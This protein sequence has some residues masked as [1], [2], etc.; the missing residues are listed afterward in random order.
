MTGR[1]KAWASGAGLL[2]VAGCKFLTK[3][4]TKFNMKPSQLVLIA[5][6]GATAAILAS[7]ATS[8]SHP[9]LKTAGQ[10]GRVD[11]SRYAG[12]WYEQARL[13]NS[14]QKDDASAEA[15][16]ALL[17]DGT[18]QVVN[19]ETRA[20]GSRHTAKGK[21]TAVPGS[22]NSRLR[23][24]FE[25][26]AALVPAAEEGNYWIIKLAPDYSVALVG[27]P[28]RQFLWLLSRKQ[29]LSAAEKASYLEDAR[30]QGFDTS[31]LIH[32]AALRR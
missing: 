11:I 8:R 31:R 32:R 24:K 28:D 1:R 7:C 18:V 19:T 10:S 9:P 14:F 12:H 16:Y 2:C 26:L 3:K 5:V 20:D 6:A 17:P 25:G 22:A 23:V 30:G 15:H 27:T 29:N 21:A 13:P 4:E